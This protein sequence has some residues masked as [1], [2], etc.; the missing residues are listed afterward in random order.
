MLTLEHQRLLAHKPIESVQRFAEMLHWNGIE[1]DWVLFTPEEIEKWNVPSS[2]LLVWYLTTDLKFN[3]QVNETPPWEA[4]GHQASIVARRYGIRDV[5]WHPF[6][7]SHGHELES[8][9]ERLRP[10][11]DRRNFKNPKWRR[12][13]KRRHPELLIPSRKKLRGKRRDSK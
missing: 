12:E 11:L 1:M 5:G 8:E 9:V 7:L 10:W 2:G 3:I 4:V 6:N 13:F